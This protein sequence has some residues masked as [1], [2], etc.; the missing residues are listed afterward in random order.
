MVIKKLFLSVSKIKEHL[1]SFMKPQ[2]HNVCPVESQLFLQSL[3]SAPS[4][5]PLPCSLSVTE[6]E[7]NSYVHL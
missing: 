6:L 2:Q 1:L 5:L 3:S 4:Q 7:K